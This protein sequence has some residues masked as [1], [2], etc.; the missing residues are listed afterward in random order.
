MI[1]TRV[2]GSCDWDDAPPGRSEGPRRLDV[3]PELRRPTGIV[4]DAARARMHDVVRLV[5]VVLMLAVACAG[6]S[7]EDLPSRPPSTVSF[8]GNDA[9][10]YVDVASTSQTRRRGLMGVEQLPT[11]QGMAFAWD[12]PVD[13]AF[14]M[15]DTLIPLSI[16]FVDEEGRVIT[17]RDMEPCTSDPCPTYAASGPYVLAIEANMGWFERN[18]IGVGD[19]AELR[20]SALPI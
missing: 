18:G 20:V 8:E 4:D 19:R 11:D 16:A 10:L 13:S 5:S 2:V 12:E 15:K 14:W 1:T 6:D 3:T 9:V 17:I 7:T